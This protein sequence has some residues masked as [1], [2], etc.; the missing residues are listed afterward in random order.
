MYKNTKDQSGYNGVN[1]T[2][3]GRTNGNKKVLNF[4]VISWT[5]LGSG[6][7]EEGARGCDRGGERDVT[8]GSFDDCRGGMR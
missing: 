1:Q 2:R 6:Q 3:G 5:I 8:A 4:I 7:V